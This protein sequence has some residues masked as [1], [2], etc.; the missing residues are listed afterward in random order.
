[1]LGNRTKDSPNSQ[2]M[3]KAKINEYFVQYLPKSIKGRKIKVQRWRIVKAI[4]Y[5]LKT[6][7]QWCNLPL[8]EFFGFTRYSWE[9][10]YYHFNRWSELG[11]WDYLYRKLLSCK[12]SL[13]DLSC[14]NLDGTH[15]PAKRGGQAIGYQGRKKC[16]TT[17]M[18][19]LT[20]NQGV[21]IGWSD[22]ISGDHNDSFDLV[23]IASEIFEKMEHSKLS[24]SGLFLNADAGFDTKDF[25]KLCFQK[26]IIANVD[27]NKRRGV[28]EEN[29]DAYVFD[30][31][32]Y[33]HRFV[34]EQLNAWVD[35]FKTLR[36]RYETS[37]KNWAQLHCIAFSVIFLRKHKLFDL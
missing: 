10:V 2:A 29:E 27:K 36:V 8:R 21:P 35:G 37:S 25:R 16:K 31:E 3:T 24:C 22:P 13:L 23:K 15:T 32:L 4:L 30:K 9:S 17:N 34:V 33:D 5:K 20:D 12:R 26:D 1:M 11:L 14:I 28:K 6:G 7:I 18:L 19:I